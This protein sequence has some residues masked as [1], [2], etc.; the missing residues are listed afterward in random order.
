MAIHTDVDDCFQILADE[1]VNGMDRK[2]IAEQNGVSQ[3]TVSNVVSLKSK[4]SR[5]AAIK[6]L[7]ATCLFKSEADKF[8]TIKGLLE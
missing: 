2:T 8:R 3:P 1:Y 4:S 5:L 6:L 7:K